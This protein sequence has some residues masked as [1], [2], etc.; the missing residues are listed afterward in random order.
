[1]DAVLYAIH[2]PVTY[3]PSFPDPAKSGKLLA[4]TWMG[5]PRQQ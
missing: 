5:T 4:C 1:M 2:G 3:D